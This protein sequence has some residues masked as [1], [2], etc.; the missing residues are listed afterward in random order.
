LSFADKDGADAFNNTHGRLHAATPFFFFSWI[1]P[2]IYSGRVRIEA[3]LHPRD[4]D[5]TRRPRQSRQARPPATIPRTPTAQDGGAIAQGHAGKRSSPCAAPRNSTTIAGVKRSRAS[6]HR[7]I[8]TRKTRRAEEG[9]ASAHLCRAHER[10]HNSQDEEGA[11]LTA[12]KGPYT[13]SS[14]SP[15]GD[16]TATGDDHL[17][18]ETRRWSHGRLPRQP[19][20]ATSYRC[21]STRRR[22]TVGADPVGPSRVVATFT[23]GAHGAILRP[24][25]R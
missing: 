5:I 4:V 9:P 6:R 19:K 18:W 14:R 11:S 13:G 20:P 10:Q 16:W 7:S 25:T 23:H 17:A 21:R 22:R 12:G 3:R 1:P 2:G 24:V 15:Q 8:W